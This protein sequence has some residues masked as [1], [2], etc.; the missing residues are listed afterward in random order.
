MLKSVKLIS[1][2]DAQGSAKVWVLCYKLHI[3]I[4]P[5][6]LLSDLVVTRLRL[7]WY[8]PVCRHIMVLRIESLSLCRQLPLSCFMAS[9]Q[10]R[11]AVAP[12][13]TPACPHCSLHSCCTLREH[14]VVS[15][16]T[17]ELLLKSVFVLFV[18]RLWRHSWCHKE[19]K[20]LILE[21][22]FFR[23]HAQY[24]FICRIA[25]PASMRQK[26]MRFG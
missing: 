13:V 15:S 6:P 22:Q 12:V 21:K 23:M 16:T 7:Y 8:D 19:Y 3:L 26:F 25:N 4:L 5:L 17:F 1:Y 20:N 9:L 14:N 24:S 2:W 11:L 18:V 10:P